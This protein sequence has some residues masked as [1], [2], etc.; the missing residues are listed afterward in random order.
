MIDNNHEKDLIRTLCYTQGYN[1]LTVKYDNYN[2]PNDLT[3]T[4]N[5]CFIKINNAFD[6]HAVFIMIRIIL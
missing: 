2:Y 6:F 1:L 3:V 5:G 4:D